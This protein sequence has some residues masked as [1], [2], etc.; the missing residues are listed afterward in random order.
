MV[1]IMRSSVLR[2]VE[3]ELYQPHKFVLWILVY[4]RGIRSFQILWKLWQITNDCVVRIT[5]QISFGILN[6]W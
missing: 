6:H 2:A 4:I 5:Y 3:F 1:T